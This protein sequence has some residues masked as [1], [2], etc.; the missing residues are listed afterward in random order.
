[1][2]VKILLHNAEDLFVFM[3]Y[4]KGENLAQLSEVKWQ[5]LT[6][7]FKQNKPLKKLFELAELYLKHD[8]DIILLCEVGGQ[9]SLDNFNQ[10]FL[11][12]KYD[13]HSPPSNSDRGID[14]GILIK[15]DFQ[16]PYEVIS[17]KDYVLKNNKKF[18]RDLLELSFHKK[19]KIFHTHLKSKLSKAQDFEGR[20][21]REAE[22]LG[23]MDFYQKNK[24]HN[25]PII[26]SGDFNGSLLDKDDR[27]LSPLNDSELYHALEHIP[28]DERV[29]YIYFKHQNGFKNQIDYFLINNDFKHII[30]PNQSKFLKFLD[31]QVGELP[32]AKNIKEKQ[33]YPSDHYP[34]LLQLIL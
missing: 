12:N 21:Q 28:Q 18:S 14:L 17:H 9:E 2:K 19:F 20:S 27:E 32:W 16:S 4:Y 6:T 13:A 25:I 3:D 33:S 23:L 7:S 10:Y 11:N 31:M 26:F 5:L 8:P 15:K 34:L 22:V 30:D 24:N 29:S 1:M